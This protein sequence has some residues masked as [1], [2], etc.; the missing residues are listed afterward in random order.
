MKSHKRKDRKPASVPYGPLGVTTPIVSMSRRLLNEQGPVS[1]ETLGVIE[2]TE[3]NFASSVDGHPLAVICFWA[4]SSA[5]C[6]AFAPI[7][8]AAAGRNPDVLFSRVNAE[9]QQAIGAQFDVRST[10]TLL[11]FRSNIIVYARAGVLQA[12]ELDDVLA[13]VRALDMEEV[14]RKVVS[15]EEVALGTAGASSTDGGSQAAADT[16]LL[17]IETYLRPSLRGPGSALMDAVPR[18]AAGGLVAIRNAF[19]PE[20]AE[21]MHR[22]LDTCTAWRVYEGYEG[23]FHY[24]HHNLFDA[25]DFPA[26]LAGCSKIFDSPSTKAWATRLSGRSCPGPAEVSAAWYLPGD[27]SLPH[28]DVAPSGPN[29]SRQFAF[30]WHLAKDWRPEWGG[31]LFWCSKGC[32]LPPEFNT[33][34]LF[35]VGPESTH[36]VTHVSPY[37]QGKRLAINGWWTG[38]ATTGAPVWKGPDRISAGSSEIVIY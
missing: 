23:D 31:A 3:Q 26:D 25:P 38:P 35:N 16:S 13:A 37:A 9:D 30:V 18:L 5:P 28:N 32:Y 34:W 14:R 10:P 7:F 22:S 36:F 12:R 33:L 21:R 4:P 1:S 20:F 6:R 11:I 27:H 15:V 24:H 29:L 2:L 19:E 17:S 8:A